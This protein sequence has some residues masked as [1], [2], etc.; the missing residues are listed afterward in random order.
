MNSEGLKDL[1]LTLKGFTFKFMANGLAE[2]FEA[3]GACDPDLCC[4]LVKSI[5]K[6]RVFEYVFMCLLELLKIRYLF[7]FNYNSHSGGLIYIAI[8]LLNQDQ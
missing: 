5:W 4:A 6:L 1:T 3:S 8:S 2:A 7:C